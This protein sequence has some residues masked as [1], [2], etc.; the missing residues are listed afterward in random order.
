MAVVYRSVPEEG[1]PQMAGLLKFFRQRPLISTLTLYILYILFVLTVQAL[2]KRLLPD[3][4]AG[5][6]GII[7]ASI[8]IAAVLTALGWWHAVG[9][10][11]PVEWRNM[12]L[13]WLPAFVL[14][15]PPLV[16]GIKPVVPSE[17]L[18]LL[19]GYILTGFAEESINRGL[20]L[21]I[22]A[23]L[24]IRKSTLIM[25]ILFG[26]SHLTNLMVRAN[27]AIVFAQAVGAF[28]DGF[29]FG[30]LRWRTNTI[31]PLIILHM[32]H[33]LLLQYTRLPAIPLDVVQVTILLFYGIYILRRRALESDR[34]L[35]SAR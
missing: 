17:L 28:C 29:A 10:T 20:Y 23:P 16:M 11:S 3:V 9:Y 24:G 5:F 1:R 13:Y 31:W 35:A 25:A 7:A 27:P 2:S 33:D 14:T 8:L 30:A 32:L 22:L 6:V 4:N 19:V 21:R 34:A 26:L 12:R 18:Y 15:V